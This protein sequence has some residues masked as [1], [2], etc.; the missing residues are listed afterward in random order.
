[1]ARRMLSVAAIAGLSVLLLA[2]GYRLGKDAA[3]PGRDAGEVS[4]ADAIGLAESDRVTEVRGNPGR[5]DLALADG[6]RVWTRLPAESQSFF[7]L[8]NQHAVPFQIESKMTTRSRVA[9]WVGVVAAPLVL[10]AAAVGVP[11]PRA[12]GRHS[13]AAPSAPY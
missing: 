12:R 10:I 3:L 4:T 7:N 1:M 9:L 8:L 2:G 11:R 5:A 13:R 6:G